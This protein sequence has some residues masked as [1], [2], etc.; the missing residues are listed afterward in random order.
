MKAIVQDTYGS[1]DV[2]ELRDIDIPVV[3]DADVLV[4]VHAAG[5]EIGVWHVMAGKPYLLRIMG[6]GLRR[7]KVPVRGRDVAGVVKAVGKNVTRFEPGDE[8]FGTAEGSF[9]EY[10]IAP[11]A[12]I[13]IKPANLTFEQAAT[14]FLDAGLASQLDEQ[15]GDEEER[16]VSLGL[17]RSTRLLVV[18]HTYREITERSASIRIFSA[19]KA[20]RRESKDYEKRKP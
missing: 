2:L 5:V 7:P 1:A 4:R 12:R 19:R 11:E 16:W 18:C 15:H 8:V 9:A 6:F 10:A 17:D 3:G 13:A 14:V 20:T